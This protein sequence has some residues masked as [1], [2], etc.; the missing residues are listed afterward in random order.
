M[1]KVLIVDDE[2]VLLMMVS[3]LVEDLGHEAVTA[4]S[5][6]EA[7]DALAANESLP[8]VIIADVMMPLISGVELAQ[9]VRSDPRTSRVPI[10]LM[11]AAGCPRDGHPADHFLSKPFDL[12]DLA[13]LIARY[14]GD[15]V[16]HDHKV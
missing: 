4:T 6:R 12:D 11:S 1:A 13:G 7:L 5:A 3:V 9:R 2:D 14:V 8:A 16:N 15:P 10:I